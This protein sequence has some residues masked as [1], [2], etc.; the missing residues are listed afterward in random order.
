MSRFL[1][2]VFVTLKKNKTVCVYEI[3][4]IMVV[5]VNVKLNN[6]SHVIV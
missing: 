2:C 3:H 6:I 4:S 5:Y 1:F